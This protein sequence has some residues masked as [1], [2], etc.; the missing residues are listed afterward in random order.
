[1]N[2]SSQAAVISEIVAGVVWILV[3]GDWVAIP[4]PIHYIW[5]IDGCNLKVITVEPEPL[6]VAAL[7]MEYMTRPKA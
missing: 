2:V 6:S 5:P 3:D 7:D 4:V 1:V